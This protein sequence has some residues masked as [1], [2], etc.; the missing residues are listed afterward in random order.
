MGNTFLNLTNRV[1]QAFNEVELNESNFSGSRGFYQEAKDSINS[2]IFDIYIEEDIK[3][4][5]A[6][7]Q[8]SFNTTV[9]ES[10]YSLD[11]TALSVDWDTFCIQRDDAQEVREAILGSRDYKTYLKRGK[12]YSANSDT[13]STPL[14]AV[15]KNNNNVILF[16]TPDKVFTVNYEYY[17]IPS[18][19]V[20]FDDTTDIPVQLEQMIVDRALHHAYMFRDNVEQAALVNR[21]Y[22][23]TVN[24]VRR[25]LIPQF[26]NV[27]PLG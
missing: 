1:L 14:I 2:A 20:N 11:P 24:K 25:V 7:S 5:F 10:T 17:S 21:R 13:G 27:T 19:L 12:E 18:P 22:E 15:R 8:G 16:P 4:S 23:S 26:N 9:N 6:W 3:W